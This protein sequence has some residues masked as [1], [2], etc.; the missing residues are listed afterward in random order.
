MGA[1]EFEF[2]PIRVSNEDEPGRFVEFTHTMAETVQGYV[3]TVRALAVGNELHV[4]QRVEFSRFVGVP[5]SFGTAD[6]IILVDDMTTG[7]TEL[8]LI[9]LKTGFHY[10]EVENNTQLLFY[11]LGAWDKYRVGRNIT[12]VRCGVYQPA[13]GGMREWSVPVGDLK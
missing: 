11:A 13:H 4:E 12:S 8:F 1:D 10:V 9:D 3:D 7:D 2:D 6:A 5:D